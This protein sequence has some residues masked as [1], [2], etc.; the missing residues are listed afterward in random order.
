MEK[1]C[2]II[3]KEKETTKGNKTVSKLLLLTKMQVVC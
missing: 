3:K 2:R 1:Y